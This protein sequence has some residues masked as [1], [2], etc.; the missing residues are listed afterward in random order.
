MQTLEL[1][2]NFGIAKLLFD[3][4]TSSTILEMNFYS[5]FLC[6]LIVL[7]LGRLITQK[8]HFLRHYD[9]PEP[10][11]GG[12]IV[13]FILFLSSYFAQFTVKFDTNIQTPLLLAFYA[14][15]GLTA[16]INSLKKGGR[17]L[18]MF[19]IAVFALL[20]VQNAIGVGLMS[21]IGENKLIGLLGG[22]ISLSGGHGTA[23]GWG[24]TFMGKPYYFE[25]ARDIG[26]ACATYGLIAGGIIGGPM[27]HYLI[28]KFD[29]KP[30]DKEDI[31]TTSDEA[32]AS[33]EKVRLVTSD[34]FITSL[35]LVALAL[36]VGNMIEYFT[37]VMAK[38]SIIGTDKTKADGVIG[39]IDSIP[40]FVWCLFSGIIIRNGFSKLNIHQVF[41]REVGVIG[42]VA[43]SLFLSM[44]IMTLNLV[45]LIKLAIP[46]TILLIVQ[47]IAIIIYVRYV[48]F[49]LCGRNY[50]AACIVAGHCG[51]GLGAT[52]TAIANL[53]VVTNHF[54]PSRIA[55][56]IVPI[57][58]GF[59]VDI[60]N[61]F[62]ITSFL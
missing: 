6:M 12:I 18:V 20:F 52:P 24:N 48:T 13:A 42:N 1:I 40:T 7:I 55:F 45:E 11:T 58:G 51:F 30:T 43:L 15:V 54:G 17:L 28:K 33:P 41:D 57:M 56:L 25:E 59:L 34:S 46:I 36:F 10:V 61:V 35:S 22:S 62:A 4:K 38:S 8:S 29:L 47:T 21:A 16:D 14:T 44:A 23:G 31:N 26:I 49:N 19:A 32:F 50:D 60:A 37:E 5:T 2:Q 53:Q 9:I 27:A 39:F 3:A